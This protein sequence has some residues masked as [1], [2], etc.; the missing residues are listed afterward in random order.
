MTI[1]CGPVFIVAKVGDRYRSFCSVQQYFI[2][3]TLTERCLRL[4]KIFEEPENRIPIQ[5]ELLLA[6]DKPE[7]FWTAK[8]QCPASFPF[9]FPY[10]ATCLILGTS[11]EATEGFLDSTKLFSTNQEFD[12]LQSSDDV[13]II[14]ISKPHNVRYCFVGYGPYGLPVPII[15]PLSAAAFLF[16]SFDSDGEEEEESEEDSD[17][18]E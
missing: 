18:K 9:P 8:P 13:T 6:Q 2:H 11:F 1:P 16:D 4:I 10:L 5:Q 12:N 15:T 17:Y 14:D 7:E 3:V